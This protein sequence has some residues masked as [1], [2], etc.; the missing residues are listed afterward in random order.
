MERRVVVT[1]MGAVSPLGL[2]VPTLWQGIQEARSGFGPV[3]LCDTEK[4]DSKIAGEV[5]GFDAQNYMDR[6]EVRRNDRLIHFA[7]AAFEKD[8]T[9]ADFLR[10]YGLKHLPADAAIR[11]KAAAMLLAQGASFAPATK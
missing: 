11:Q 8:K 3:T 9:A 6:K 4:L 5:K 1:G 10:A 2:D 7:L